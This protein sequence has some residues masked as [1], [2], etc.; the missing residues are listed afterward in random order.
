VSSDFD[1]QLH[2]L[3]DGPAHAFRDWPATHF[4]IGPSG[5]YTIWDGDQF[6]YVGCAWMHRDEAHP[7]ALGVFG[8]LKSHASGLR[9][10]NQ[11]AIYICDRFV[12][13]F[14]TE[15]EREALARGQRLLDAA[16]RRYIHEHLSY[17]V[18]LT[19]GERM[20]LALETRVQREGLPRAGRPQIN[21]A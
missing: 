2:A 9:S 17:R 11:F 10:G 3:E 20:A 12:V 6:L 8:R 15:Q 1:E 21:P 19:D 16:T 18:A 5:V 14:L 4:E 7:K 13:P